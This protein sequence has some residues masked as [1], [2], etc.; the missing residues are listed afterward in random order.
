MFENEHFVVFCP[1]AS[2]A[3]FEMWVVPKRNNAYFERITDEEKYACG[4]ALKNALMSIFKGLE[5][6]AYNFYIHTAPCDGQEYN[7]YRWHIEIVPRT[8]VWA[9]FELSTG[10]EVSTIEPE[11]AAPFLRSQLS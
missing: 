10:I 3:A 4:E 9:G 8:A 6:P 5:D 11:I 7:H 2:R 1:Y